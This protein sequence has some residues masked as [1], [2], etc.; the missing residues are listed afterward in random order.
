MGRDFMIVWNA[1]GPLLGVLVGG[2]ITWMSQ[3][4]KWLADGKKEEYREVLS[5]IMSVLPQD[6]KQEEI[7]K[8]LTREALRESLKAFDETAQR[9]L[10][11]IASQV[12]IHNEMK[13]LDAGK[14]WHHATMAFSKNPTKDNRDSLF[15]VASELR[16][17]IVDLATKVK[18]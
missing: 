1:I 3:S 6:P 5:A 12:L 13:R 14:R 15:K 18:P 16:K 8:G 17:G 10:V 4:R 11:V 2:Y 7:D 9:S